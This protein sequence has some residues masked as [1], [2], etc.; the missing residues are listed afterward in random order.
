LKKQQ[1]VFC[2]SCSLEFLQ[3]LCSLC[4]SSFCY[5]LSSFTVKNSSVAFA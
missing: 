2:C 4:V 3:L 5:D 1:D